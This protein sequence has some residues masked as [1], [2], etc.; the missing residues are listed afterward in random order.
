MNSDNENGPQNVN[1]VANE[2][3]NPQN[4]H[5]K[6]KKKKKIQKTKIYPTF[7]FLFI[8]NLSLY[9]YRKY[10]S[11]RLSSLSIS[12]YPILYKFQFYR[13]IIH[14]FIHY[15]ICH[16]LIEIIITYYI[17]K[18]LEKMI[19]TLLTFSLILVLILSTSFLFF[20]S[21]IIVKFLINI[22]NFSYNCDFV[23]ECGMS[24]L[25]FALYTY[26]IDFKRNKNKLIKLL[27]FIAIRS[28]FSSIYFIIFLYFFTPNKSIYGNICGIIS[29]NLI[30]F[31]FGNK[32]FPKY[33]GVY[34]FEEYFKLN[35]YKCCY[36]SII[37]PSQ[38][39]KVYLLEIFPNISSN[40]ILFKEDELG[41]QLTDI[42]N[43]TN[44][45]II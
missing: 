24:C 40:S 25:L 12:L 4:N 20:L 11:I 15:N 22:F 29:I 37:E 28:K 16:L 43:S 27:N 8:I 21:M 14:H 35:N 39:M 7:I 1:I 41:I 32:F 2:N 6:S 9:L 44:N 34:D 19:G 10:N 31:L 3:I 5:K 23:Y 38:D 26:L 13:F 45:N 17:C 18:N 36:I 30:K 33:E 42:D